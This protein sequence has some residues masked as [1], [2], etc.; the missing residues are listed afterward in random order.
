MSETGGESRLHPR[1]QQLLFPDS[2]RS[3][4]VLEAPDIVGAWS[5]TTL[6]AHAKQH[7]D[8]AQ[9]S[10]K[11][12]QRE[13]RKHHGTTTESQHGT[14]IGS[15][16]QKQSY[17]I[18]QGRTT[19]AVSGTTG[20]IGGEGDGTTNVSSSLSLSSTKASG[21]MKTPPSPTSPPVTIAEQPQPQARQARQ[22]FFP[23][24]AASSLSV[25]GV[26]DTP[27]Q[28]RRA[29]TRLLA[30]LTDLEKLKQG[31]WV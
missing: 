21:M 10:H 15:Q 25:A 2:L 11:H 27:K 16:D 12:R 4:E 31:E 18:V 28:V 20:E 8:S 19:T 14:I 24:A 5:Q 6:A 17:A 22:S 9:T 7:Y 3:D 29:L 26:G 23:Q 1:T 13:E 30:T